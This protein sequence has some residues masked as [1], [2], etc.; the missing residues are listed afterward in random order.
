MRLSYWMLSIWATFKGAPLILQSYSVI[1]CA[2]LSY[3]S[4][5]FPPPKRRAKKASTSM[6]TSYLPSFPYSLNLPN[7]LEITLLYVL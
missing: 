2:P 1:L 7:R 3:I 6:P 5:S 4:C